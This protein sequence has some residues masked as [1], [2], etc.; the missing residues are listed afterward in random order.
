MRVL[1]R[2]GNFHEGASGVQKSAHL[3]SK[4]EFGFQ[5]VG[6]ALGI[7]HAAL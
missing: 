6:H 2:K 5:E 4:A 7:V 1:V 3:V